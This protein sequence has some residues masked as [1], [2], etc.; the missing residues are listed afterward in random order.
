MPI[1]ALTLRSVANRKATAGLVVFAIGLSVALLL[2]VERVRTE[3]KASFANTISGTDLIVGARSGALPLLLYS[4]FRIGNA[5]NNISWK[6]YRAILRSPDIAW[7]IPSHWAIPTAATAFSAR[8]AAIS[9]ITATAA[10]ARFP[11]R[12]AVRSTT[13]ST[14]C[15]APR[16]PMRWAT[17]RAIPSW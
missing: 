2:G 7:T 3:A 14:R 17:G 15:W 1:V 8:I 16:S 12:R 11:S 6:S 13:C 10:G 5:T 4:V 9:S